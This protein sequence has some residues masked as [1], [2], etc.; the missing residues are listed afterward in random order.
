M[1]YILALLITCLSIGQSFAKE[2][3]IKIETNYGVIILKLYDNTPLHT[4]NLVKLCKEHYFDST[5]FH[6]VIP[7]FVIQGGDPDSKHAGPEKQLGDGDLSYLVPAEINAVN[8]HKRG[9]LGMARDNNPEKKSSACQFYIV[10][11]KV[12][13]EEQLNTISTKTNRVFSAEQRKVYTTQGGTPFLDG[14]YTVFGEVTK[15]MEVVDT[16]A[17]LARN[18]ADRPNAD[19]RMLKVSVLRNKFL[20]IF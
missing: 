3:S 1:R 5:L 17:Q 8:Y 16:I 7:S 19:V 9:A 4:A 12:V 10:V 20:G 11:G 14:N 6:R 18:A 2:K 15:G 13:T